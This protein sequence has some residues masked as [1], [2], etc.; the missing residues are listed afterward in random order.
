MNFQ[1]EWEKEHTEKEWGKYP[2]ENV[3]KFIARNYFKEKN[4]G[5]IKIL[6]AGCGVGA[7]SWFLAR[8]GFDVYGFDFS[9]PA[10]KKLKSR[11]E[12]EALYLDNLHK[13]EVKD[14]TLLDY[15]EKF[16]DVIVDSA[17][18]PCLDDENIMKVLNNYCR[19]L[20]DKDH[21]KL[22][23]GGL[24]EVNGV[25]G[26]ETGK[27]IGE[28]MVGEMREGRLAGNFYNNFFDRQRLQKLFLNAGFKN[29]K[30]DYFVE[31][32]DDPALNYRY[33]NVIVSKR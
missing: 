29:I 17:M 4:K 22:F 1:A 33:F 28:F 16:F 5:Q 10:I 12:K 25:F 18:L 15:P 31:Q 19:I 2:S 26:I 11:F 23:C 8:E 27:K 14:A 24:H 6:D 32:F 9:E 13:F 20:N 30:I 21:A 3:I 7:Q